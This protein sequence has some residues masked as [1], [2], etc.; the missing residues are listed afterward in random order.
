MHPASTKIEIIA[1]ITV[2]LLN[3]AWDAVCLK[4]TTDVQPEIYTWFHSALN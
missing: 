1:N 2:L 3:Y 4:G